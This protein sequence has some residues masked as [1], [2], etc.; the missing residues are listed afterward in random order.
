MDDLV[1]RENRSPIVTAVNSQS[2]SLDSCGR[3]RVCFP[4]REG[5]AGTRTAPH[6]PSH[7][8]AIAGKQCPGRHS[9][10]PHT[11]HAGVGRSSYANRAKG[12]RRPAG[13]RTPRPPHGL[14]GHGGDDS[15]RALSLLPRSL[16]PHHPTAA[17]GCSL[18]H[19]A[20]LFLIGP[21]F[22]P[23]APSPCF[24]AVKSRS[25]GGWAPHPT[26][27]GLLHHFRTASRP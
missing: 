10:P 6:P 11:A 25:V 23:L 20:R 13:G 26:Q 15:R 5:R 2:G 21:L 27:V 22:A 9:P 14:G 3:R 4:P 17:V 12:S 16:F 1:G 24:E 7:A 8:R 19:L 18:L